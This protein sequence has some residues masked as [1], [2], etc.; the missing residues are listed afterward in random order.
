MLKNT[1]LIF[2][3]LFAF[4]AVLNA[5]G[6]GR[7][8]EFAR[9]HVAALYPGTEVVGI[10]CVGTDSDGDGYVSCT[11]T[12]RGDSNQTER[13]DLECARAIGITWQSGCKTAQPNL[14]YNGT[15]VQ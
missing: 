2:F 7:A 6:P 9:E 10:V 14:R 1:L 3:C 15:T 11:A 4:S 5:C 13:L 8:E 12:I